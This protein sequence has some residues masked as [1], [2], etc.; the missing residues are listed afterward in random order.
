MHQI[1][2]DCIVRYKDIDNLMYTSKY[3]IFAGNKDLAK[4]I[5]SELFLVDNGVSEEMVIDVEPFMLEE[6]ALMDINKRFFQVFGVLSDSFK[7]MTYKQFIDAY[8][9]FGAT[10]FTNKN[11]IVSYVVSFKGITCR[12]VYTHGVVSLDDSEVI[13]RYEGHNYVF[14]DNLCSVYVGGMS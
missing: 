7:K 2:Y 1:L 14:R 13:F 6:D 3:K 10:Y 5:V 8:Q 4:D 9:T 11:G 12:A